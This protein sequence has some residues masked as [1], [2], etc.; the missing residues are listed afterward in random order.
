MPFANSKI[1]TIEPVLRY[2][3][4]AVAKV[5]QVRVRLVQ[6]G[7][8][9]LIG[10]DPLSGGLDGIFDQFDTLGSVCDVDSVNDRPGNERIILQDLLKGGAHQV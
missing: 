5:L 3:L 7:I 2:L 9:F 8:F 4:H 1:V 6:I 10:F